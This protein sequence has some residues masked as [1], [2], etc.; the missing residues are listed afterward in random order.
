MEYHKK[1]IHLKKSLQ[2]LDKNILSS[3]YHLSE[4]SI[5]AV[6]VLAI[7]ITIM[8]Y[9]LLGY[10]IIIW[11]AVLIFISLLRLMS[12]LLYKNK[13]QFFTNKKWYIL[14]IAL[15][16]SSA[17]C[18][19]LLS[20]MALPYVNDFY[21]LLIILLLVGL[22]AG[23]TTSLSLDVRIA[24]PYI[25]MLIL[26]VS[27]SLFIYTIPYYELIE[28]LLV[29]FIISQ[30]VLILESNKRYNELV[31]KEERLI[32][33]RNTLHEKENLLNYFVKE[34]PVAIFSYNKKLKLMNYN[35]SLVSLLKTTNDKLYKFD[36]TTLSNKE[37][38]STISDALIEGSKTY[39]GLY[40]SLSG[41]ELW[42]KVVCF[43]FSDIYNEVIGGIAIIE[44]KTKEHEVT[45]QLEYLVE[46]DILTGL[47]N[48]RGY[49]NAI[50]N[51]VSH[52]QHQTDYSILFY[53][54]L[55]RFKSINDSLGHGIGDKVLLSVSNR[56]M[57]SVDSNCI[58]SR[59]G[60][61][62][63]I[64]I[65]PYI[66]KNK[67]EAYAISEKYA[68]VLKNIFIDAFIVDSLHLYIQASVGIVVIEPKYNNIEEILRYADITMYH[69]K[70][71]KDNI[72]YYDSSLDKKQKEL[73]I[74]QNNLAN[75]T[76]NDQIALYF[77]PIVKMKDDNVFSAELLIRWNHP[78]KGL[79]S[80]DAFIPLAINAGLLSK[81]TWWIID[82][83]FYQI[84]KWK[85]DKQWKLDYIS[86]NINSQQLIENNFAES[87]LSKLKYYGLETK[88]VIIEIT[89]RALI[90]NFL[91]TQDVIN[92]LR[93][94]GVRCAIDDFG[95]GYSSL[96]YLKKLSFHT[97]KIDREF[98]KDI[99][100]NSKDLLLVSSI[101]TIGRE[102]GYDIVIEGIEDPTQKKLL[103]DLDS[104]LSY[105][106]YFFSKAL[107]I[108]EFTNTFLC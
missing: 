54:D 36:L 57:K 107:P 46:Q 66:A 91:N 76:A 79:L 38:I 106:G 29:I 51:L 21:Q 11:G 40:L 100:F 56:L 74:L 102:F 86:I 1:I 7:T 44:D 99:E 42:V 72:S 5:I 47:R 104:E 83:L 15:T 59:L 13:N 31:K 88:D 26:P 92:I 9:P 80:P 75:S 24:I 17:I 90:D 60:G 82:K 30:I 81:M 103:L 8:Y 108:D 63:F 14:F 105:Q 77:Q 3:L 49:T 10:P 84:A 70:N 16:Y 43:P 62:E 71:A 65:A 32:E 48:R 52:E 12:A 28:V 2:K 20:F 78:T 23:A 41:V 50:K 45:K 98:V 4:K 34:A 96:S 97:L 93:E 94:E 19:S 58:I 61:D 33:V 39:E 73:F 27:I 87:F 25:L 18:T 64:L 55:N 6:I 85:K 89:E 22:S 53:L 37:I 101:L 35:Q 68:T 67:A 95:T 69:A